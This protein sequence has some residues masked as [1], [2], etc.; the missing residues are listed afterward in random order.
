MHIAGFYNLK[1]LLIAAGIYTIFIDFIAAIFCRKKLSCI[2][3]FLKV[4][5]Q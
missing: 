4:P 1:I 2:L 3:L 5:V